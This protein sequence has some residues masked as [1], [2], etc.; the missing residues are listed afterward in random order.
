MFKGFALLLALPFLLFIRW[1]IRSFTRTKVEKTLIEKRKIVY[2]K[3]KGNLNQIQ[4]EQR[5]YTRRVRS[6]WRREMQ[7]WQTFRITYPHH[8]NYAVFGVVVPDSF[9]LAADCL[10]ELGFSTGWLPETAALRYSLN[11]WFDCNLLSCFRFHNAKYA[12]RRFLGSNTVEDTSFA[13][14]RSRRRTEF[15]IPID[16]P[17]GFWRPTTEDQTNNN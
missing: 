11:V 3:V 5:I 10:D 15:L 6:L 7:N 4:K 2:R 16:A 8:P 17:D 13:E 12:F 1:M 9:E 14:F